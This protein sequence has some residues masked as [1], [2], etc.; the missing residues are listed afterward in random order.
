[1]N[2]ASD[3]SRALCAMALLLTLTACGGGEDTPAQ[4]GN[5]ATPAAP[6]PGQPAS[7]PQLRCAP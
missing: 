1:M 2:V 6:A 5:T 3:L 4:T 7:E